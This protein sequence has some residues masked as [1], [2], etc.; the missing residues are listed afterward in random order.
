MRFRQNG[1]FME[2]FGVDEKGWWRCVLYVSVEGVST[3]T[4]L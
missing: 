4:F 2:G 3:V 1:G